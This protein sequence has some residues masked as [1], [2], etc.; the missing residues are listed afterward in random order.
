[1]T[2][3]E[4]QE[5]KEQLEKQRLEEELQAQIEM[6][7]SQETISGIHIEEKALVARMDHQEKLQ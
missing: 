1:M 3:K 6:Q 4:M 5:L 2:A 7:R